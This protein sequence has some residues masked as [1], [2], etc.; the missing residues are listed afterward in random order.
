MGKG[1]NLKLL[2]ASQADKL[3]VMLAEQKK[4]TDGQFTDIS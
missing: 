1:K 4:R 3:R 2:S